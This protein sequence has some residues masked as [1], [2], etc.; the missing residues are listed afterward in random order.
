MNPLIVEKKM[1][2]IFIRRWNQEID[3]YGY[4]N[5]VVIKSLLGFEPIFTD[6]L[7]GCT[8]KLG[9]KNLVPFDK[10]EGEEYIGIIIPELENLG[11]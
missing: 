10:Y 2:N 3:E 9:K 4:I 5:L 6:C 1:A 7:Y 8:S 11:S